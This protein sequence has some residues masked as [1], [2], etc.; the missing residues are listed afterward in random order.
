MITILS[1]THREGSFTLKVAQAYQQ[2]FTRKGHKTQLFDFRTIPD[3][4]LFENMFG[5][6]TKAGK[7]MRG[8]Y[9]ENVD[10]FLLV[11]PEYNGSFP[12]IIKV[13]IDSI[14]PAVL[15]GK[16]IALTGVASG[17]FGNLRGLEHLTG[18][19]HHLNLDVVGIKIALSGIDTMYDGEQFTWP[20][21]IMERIDKQINLLVS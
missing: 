5:R 17:R 15:K 4:Y 8:T 14:P 3:N 21:D 10:R 12:G 1:G 6:S 20:K 18:I 7:E 9:F 19:L 16:K 13:V 2:F 11:A